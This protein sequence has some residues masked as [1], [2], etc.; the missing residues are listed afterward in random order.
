MST[1]KFED[2]KNNLFRQGGF[3]AAVVVCLLAM[4]AGAYSAINRINPTKIQDNA[5]ITI[6]SEVRGAGNELTGVPYETTKKTEKNVTTKKTVKATEAKNNVA[7][8]FSMPVSGT[9]IKR[10]SEDELIFSETY[11]DWRLHDGI[12]IAADKGTKVK[13][14]GDGKVT[15]I[16]E[17]ALLGTIVVIDHGNGIV[18]YYCGLNKT[19]AVKKGQSVEV[20]TVVGTIDTIPSESVEQPHLHFYVTKSGKVVSPVDTLKLQQ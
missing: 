12:D 2:K 10:Y 14:A 17:D 1:M 18:A 7:G 3:Y 16:K 13:A 8:F 9:I 19:P 11:N 4:G 5:Q 15:D 20:G 6:T